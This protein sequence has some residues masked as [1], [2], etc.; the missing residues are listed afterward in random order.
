MAPPD[1][2]GQMPTGDFSR[3]QELCEQLEQ[4]WKEFDGSTDG[5][6]LEPFLRTAGETLRLSV[7]YE[8]IKTE[9]PHRHKNGLPWDLA[10]YLTKY[11]ELGGADSLSPSLILEE[12]LVRKRQ[13]MQFSLASYQKRFVRQFPELEKLLQKHDSA[14]IASPAAPAETASPLFGISPGRTIANHYVVRNRLGG[15]AYGEVWKIVDTNGGIEKALKIIMH[16]MDTEE[17]KTELQAL[18]KIKNLESPFILR[19]ESYWVEEGRLLI[20]MELARG[21]SLRDCL[22]KRKQEGHTGLAVPELLRYIRE[23]ADA[24]DYLHGEK[25]VHRDIKPDN[26]LLVGNHA[27]IADMGLAK[28]LSSE[29][30]TMASPLG[31]APYMATEVWNERVSSRSDQYSLVVSYAE[32]RQG[33]L[34]FK[35]NKITDFFMAHVSGRA[36][37]EP[38]IILGAEQEVILKGLSKDPAQRFISCSDFVEELVRVVPRPDRGAPSGRVASEPPAKKPAPS[39]TSPGAPAPSKALPP[40]PPAP[41]P[42]GDFQPVAALPVH[43]EAETAVQTLDHLKPEPPSSRPDTESR[44]S[45]IHSTATPIET[46]STPEEIS[47]AR[48]P[49]HE[50]KKTGGEET[51]QVLPVLP[52]TGSAR[53]PETVI[54]EVT[55]TAVKDAFDT[56][57]SA[58]GTLAPDTLAKRRSD[59]KPPEAPPRVL[60]SAAEVSASPVA[61]AVDSRPASAT[62]GETDEIESAGRAAMVAE[63]GPQPTEGRGPTWQHQKAKTQN[64]PAKAPQEP[65]VVGV[66]LIAKPSAPPR[67][68][69]K[70]LRRLAQLALV[71]GVLVGAGVM[72]AIFIPRPDPATAVLRVLERRIASST[73]SADFEVLVA[74]VGKVDLDTENRQKLLAKVKD[75]WLSLAHTELMKLDF[76]NT[77]KTAA[78]LRDRKD[79]LLSASEIAS[80]KTIGDHAANASYVHKLAQ[81]SDSFLRT[82]QEIDHEL[83]DQVR[84][85]LKKHIAKEWKTFAGR[86]PFDTVEEKEKALP[87][88]MG[89]AKYDNEFRGAREDK[90]TDLVDSLLKRS[91]NQEWKAALASLQKAEKYASDLPQS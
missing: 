17:A 54:R 37:F 10:F 77:I 78:A 34:P 86:Q 82:D 46:S 87:I 44:Q 4:A 62:S 50:N 39:G 72:A 9:M 83:P 6:D 42:A 68:R 67:A 26:I 75:A 59:T 38:G 61:A 90:Q 40:H 66:K 43:P 63:F 51:K 23:A 48:Q 89:L 69:S 71:V 60:D 58:Y 30:S 76:A 14:P 81:E 15:G 80:V 70:A 36:Q 7:L 88:W 56:S 22:K 41:N 73:N 55:N 16:S 28:L 91:K 52:C 74:E 12:C 31:S 29:R 85:Y 21:G 3:I 8:L 27:K 65:A 57:D 25:I 24:L 47:C 5:V 19:P 49:A 2:F 11:P 84:T 53:V 32:L 18:E 20:V 79:G 1:D 64:D 33:K 35:G 13:G 45:E